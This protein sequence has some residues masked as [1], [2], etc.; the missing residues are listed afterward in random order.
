MAIKFVNLASKHQDKHDFQLEYG[1][2][3]LFADQGIGPKVHSAWK[4]RN[5]AGESE[6]GVIVFELWDASL[7]DF[8]DEIS[9]KSRNEVPECV[10]KKLKSQLR[11]VH[12]LNYAHLDL[13][14]GNVLIKFDDP[15]KK[16]KK[17]KIVDATLCDFGLSMHIND[18]TKTL[19][20]EAAKSLEVNPKTKD[21]REIDCLSLENIK[22]EWL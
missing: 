7:G 18:V 15:D 19:F 20:K 6:I 2:T 22:N 14:A 21:P 1:T 9:E 5:D 8:M 12:D 3:G 17:R 4:I 10:V 16:S 13:H 11:K